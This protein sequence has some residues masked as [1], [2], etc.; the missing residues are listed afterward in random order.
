MAT[1]KTSKKYSKNSSKEIEIVSL[2]VTRAREYDDIFFFD[3]ILNGVN[4]YG[5]RLIEGKNGWFVSFPSKKPEKKGGK[6]YNHCWATLPDDAL[7]E[8]CSA[9][10]E[11]C[12]VDEY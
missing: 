10:F 7:S 9:V 8:I 6:W 5:C 3:M 12:G 1:K 2:E 11:M 4:I